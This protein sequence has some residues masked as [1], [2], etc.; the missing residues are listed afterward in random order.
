MIF[1]LLDSY[2]MVK[3]KIMFI[4]WNKENFLYVLFILYIELN[5]ELKYK[6]N[7]KRRSSFYCSLPGIHVQAANESSPFLKA[8]L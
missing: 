8:Y 2:W 1:L 4:D 7:T 6:L 5:N 3:I